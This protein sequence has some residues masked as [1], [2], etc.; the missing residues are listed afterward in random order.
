MKLNNTDNLATNGWY[1]VLVGDTFKS[2]RFN[3][4]GTMQTGMVDDGGY[5]YYLNEVQGS[6]IGEMKTGLVSIA[7]SLYYFN[8]NKSNGIPYGALMKNATLPNGTKTDAMGRV[9]N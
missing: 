3:S 5:T 9:I 1:T 2:Y 6:S 8:E 4:M 7:G